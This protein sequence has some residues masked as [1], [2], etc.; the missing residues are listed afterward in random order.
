MHIT[1]VSLLGALVLEEHGAVWTGDED[2]L[3]Q[4]PAM[5]V[6]SAQISCQVVAAVTAVAQPI[7]H[8]L[9]VTLQHILSLSL[10][11]SMFRIR[12]YFHPGS[13][14]FSFRSPDPK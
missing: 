13:A 11:K 8:R 12:N 4:S 6:E 14:P 7:M 3:M 10:K 9:H 5:L 1:D 2:I